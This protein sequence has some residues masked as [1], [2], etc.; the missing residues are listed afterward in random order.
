MEKI[1]VLTFKNPDSNE[2]DEFQCAC[3]AIGC[4]TGGATYEDALLRV[5]TVVRR[6]FNINFPYFLDKLRWVI[7]DGVITP[8]RF[9]DDEL[10]DFLEPFYNNKITDYKVVELSVNLMVYD[11]LHEYKLRCD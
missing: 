1:Q 7:S 4:V 10:D 5:V 9:T 8:P 2:S 11:K 3:P 6:Y